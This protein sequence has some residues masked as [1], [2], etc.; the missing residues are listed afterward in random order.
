MY[1]VSKVKFSQSLRITA[2]QQSARGRCLE[3]RCLWNPFDGRSRARADGQTALG[4]GR[5]SGC[6]DES[7]LWGRV[8]LRIS[9]GESIHH[10]NSGCV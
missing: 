3:S 1:L 9:W 2:T 7:L 5:A 8:S 4:Y 10:G 6:R